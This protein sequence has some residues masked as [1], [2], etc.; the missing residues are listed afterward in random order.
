MIKLSDEQVNALEQIKLFLKNKDFAISLCGAG[1]SGKSLLIS[2]IIQYLESEHIKYC[3]CAPT[4]KAKTVLEH[5]THREA[6]TLHKLLSLSPKLDIFELDFN[7]L[8]FQSKSSKEIPKNGIVI[9]DEGSMI[10]DDLFD[11][12]KQKCEEL[13]TKMLFVS[14]SK[15]LAPVKSENKSKVYTLKNQIV[16]TKIFRQSEKNA[17]LDTLQTLR[18]H[19]I[20]K[21]N[22]SIGE[23]GS[24]LCESDFKSFFNLCKNGIYN[25][26]KNEDIFEA[27]ITAFKNSRVNNYNEYLTKAIFNDSEE[28]HKLEILMGNENLLFNNFQY[29]NSMDYIIKNVTSIDINIPNYHTLPGFKLTLFDTG[30]K[31]YGN[32]N[33]ISNTLNDN[34]Y[35]A[36]AYT[37]ESLRIFALES[38]TNYQ[39]SKRWKQYFNTIN[40]FAS[41]RDLYYDNRLIRGK[42]FNKGYAVT[43]HKLQGST[44]N[45]IYVDMKDINTCYDSE[46]KRQLQYVALS[47]ARHNVY[48]Y[49]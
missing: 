39:K 13:N 44:L 31:E 7:D 28:Y 20:N 47:R 49:Q 38:K 12:L 14:D 26:I 27:K 10:N 2:Y 24:L 33:I 23:D 25:A 45:N 17:I 3:L 29:Y 30:T 21:F 16:L 41:S 18:E 46:M 15:Q 37:I 6:M 32:I 35:I 1:G 22:T 48:I 11:L 42:S 43:V 4:H 40:S 19:P 36:L 8:I 5:Y 9:C 34:E